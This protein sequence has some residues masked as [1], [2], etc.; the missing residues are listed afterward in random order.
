MQK[1][2]ES[3]KKDK[4]IYQ[5]EIPKFKYEKNTA[6]EAVIALRNANFNKMQISLVANKK[7]Q[8]QKL[9]TI[10]EKEQGM[11]KIMAKDTMELK[12]QNQALQTKMRES[13]EKYD[14]DLKI[15]CK[16]KEEFQNLNKGQN[17]QLNRLLPEKD[18]HT[19]T[20]LN[21]QSTNNE[22]EQEVT[23]L[24]KSQLGVRDI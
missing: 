21:A 24:K 17:Q 2:D 11:K 6:E 10:L 1:I 3:T 19:K 5:T 23:S 18:Q 12:A 13:Q 20:I 9:N 7:Q 8:I 4:K 14:E 16:D 22:L 15:R